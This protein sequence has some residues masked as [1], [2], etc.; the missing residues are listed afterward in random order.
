MI[1][2]VKS[3]TNILNIKTQSF[4]VLDYNSGLRYHIEIKK[5]RQK[6]QMSCG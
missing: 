1:K 2:N 4:L 3:S 6:K 5:L